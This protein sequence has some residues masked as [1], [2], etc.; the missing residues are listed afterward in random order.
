MID[1][2]LPVAGELT[3]EIAVATV[4][5]VLVHVLM[6]ILTTQMNRLKNPVQ[7][8]LDKPYAHLSCCTAEEGSTLNSFYKIEHEVQTGTIQTEITNYFDHV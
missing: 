5:E 2:D 7:K 3:E 1:E 6:K 8:I 4:Q